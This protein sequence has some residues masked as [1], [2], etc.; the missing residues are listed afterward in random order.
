MRILLSLFLIIC[1]AFSTLSFTQDEVATRILNDV[2]KTYQA[3]K[4]I[5]AKFT[6]I[7]ENGQDNSKLSQSGVLHAK[8]KKFRIQ[9]G[10]QEIFCDGKTMWTYLKDANEVQISKYVPD[11]QGINPS[12]IFTMFKQGF[13]TR[14]KGDVPLANKRMVLI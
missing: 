13:L 9:L 6:M 11:E 4:T 5:K 10:G 8:G 12:V 14:H 3:Y 2:S 7:I 1:L